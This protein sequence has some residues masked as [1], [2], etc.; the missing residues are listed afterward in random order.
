MP[1]LLVYLLTIICVG[2]LSGGMAVIFRRHYKVFTPLLIIIP[3][4]YSLFLLLS[5]G[6]TTLLLKGII[7]CLVLVY[8][9]GADIR[10]H[11]VPDYIPIMVVLA[12]LIA[13]DLPSLASMCL[14][15]L[16]ITI[17]QLAAA[18]WKPGSYGGADIKLMAALGFCLGLHKG[19]AALLL[20]LSSGVV[21]VYIYRKAKRQPMNTPFPLVPYLA[22]GGCLSYILPL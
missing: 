18:I 11:E 12:A 21:C 19:I 15:A 14:S 2:L 16:L 8:A 20:G 9:A 6:P 5:F 7:L 3:V 10:T 1:L 4:L 22:A 13:T 17:P